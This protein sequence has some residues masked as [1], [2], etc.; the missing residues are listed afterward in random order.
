MKT[1]GNRSM[2][3]VLA[4]FSVCFGFDTKGR[5][6]I[7]KN[8]QMGL[9]QTKKFLPNQGNNQQNEKAT[10]RIRANIFKLYT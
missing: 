5:G 9:H 4:M 8:K 2:T 3:S 10:Y 7:S 1:S 6:N